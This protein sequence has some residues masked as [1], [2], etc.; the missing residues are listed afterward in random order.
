[1]VTPDGKWP[2]MNAE[3]SSRITLALQRAEI[4]MWEL[5]E[6]RNECC[7]EGEG[8]PNPPPLGLK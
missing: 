4:T 6:V 8:D 2:V 7:G 5:F 1:M 3:T